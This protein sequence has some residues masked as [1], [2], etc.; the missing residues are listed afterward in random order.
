MI[1]KYSDENV[2][3][4]SRLNKQEQLLLKLQYKPESALQRRKHG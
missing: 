1:K 2:K 3:R 4:F